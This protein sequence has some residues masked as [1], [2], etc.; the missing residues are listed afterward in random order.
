ML[1]VANLQGGNQHLL[2]PMHQQQT[3]QQQGGAGMHRQLPPQLMQQQRGGGMH[4][5]RSPTQDAKSLATLQQVGSYSTL[6]PCEAHE[7]AHLLPDRLAEFIGT[8]EHAAGR[9]P[10][11][12]TSYAAETLAHII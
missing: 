1:Q 10:P 7:P 9:G 4:T 8:H 5:L 3:Q 6:R 11:Q 2:P 12:H